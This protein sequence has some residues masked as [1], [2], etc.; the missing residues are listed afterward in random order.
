[1]VKVQFY[2]KMLFIF[3]TPVLIRHLW[4]LKTA[5]FLHW[6]LILAVPF[7]F[8]DIRIDLLIATHFLSKSY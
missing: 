4:Q 8:Y 2:I 1:V 6:Y 5:V 3:S 7:V